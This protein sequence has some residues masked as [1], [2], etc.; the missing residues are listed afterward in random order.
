LSE[1][2]APLEP[3]RRRGRWT[4][5]GVGLALAFLAFSMRHSLGPSWPEVT[6]SSLTFAAAGA[7]AALACLP[8]SYVMRAASVALLGMVLMLLGTEVEGPLAG[9]LIG[10]SL[11]TEVA[12]LIVLAVLPGALLFRARYRAY[13]RARLVL[14]LALLLALPFAVARATVFMDVGSLADRI[15]AG[16]A[17]AAV[18]SGLFGFM[19]ADTTAGGS[20]W[21][22]LVLGCVSGDIAL[23]SLGGAS[24]AWLVHGA[25]AIGTACAA[26]LLATG[27]YHLLAAAMARD[28]RRAARGAE[29]GT[30]A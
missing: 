19:G 2:L 1:D 8:F 23:R 29:A 13:R 17:L 24:D 27:T 26:I 25:T 28:A 20:V 4:V 9:L 12:R 22:A 6:S 16:I 3:G 14:G 5:G 15:S 30:P 10:S 21:A 11:G 7:A 18:L